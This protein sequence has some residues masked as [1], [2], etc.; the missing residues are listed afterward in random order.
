MFGEMFTKLGYKIA[1]TFESDDINSYRN[2]R[3]QF[4]ESLKKDVEQYKQNI[5]V[6]D[7]TKARLDR[8]AFRRDADALKKDWEQIG[9]DFPIR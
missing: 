6:D 9:K 3:K 5:N 2:K 4:I 7:D 1:E 8:E